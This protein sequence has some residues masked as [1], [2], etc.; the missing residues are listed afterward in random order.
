MVCAADIAGRKIG[1]QRYAAR[2]YEEGQ[3]LLR[4]MDTSERQ[5]ITGIKAGF[6]PLKVLRDHLHLVKTKEQRQKWMQELGGVAG[7]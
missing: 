5:V 3:D 1:R 7:D 6:A 2:R 4:L